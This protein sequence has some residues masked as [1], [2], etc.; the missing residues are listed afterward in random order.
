MRP[1]CVISSLLLVFTSSGCL[2]ELRDEF[3]DYQFSWKNS[4]AARSAWNQCSDVYQTTEYKRDFRR[5]FLAG[6]ESVAFGSNGC[7][8]SI[9]P[10]SYWKARFGSPEGKARTNAWFDGYSHGAVAAQGDDVAEANRM[11]TRGGRTG[12]QP[13]HGT[14]EGLP[15]LNHEMED[16]NA[17]GPEP[18]LIPPTPLP[19]TGLGI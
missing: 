8:P 9:P 19:E 4:S 13:H 10:S 3:I 11:V 14:G 5:G 7:P 2:Y 1:I 6:Y 16:M 17:P 15:S 18:L 12:C